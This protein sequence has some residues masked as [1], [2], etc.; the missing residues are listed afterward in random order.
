MSHVAS[1]ITLE[2]VSKKPIRVT[3]NSGN[4][5][6]LLVAQSCVVIAAAEF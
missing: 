4:T 5:R 6:S 1:P 2:R 3:G